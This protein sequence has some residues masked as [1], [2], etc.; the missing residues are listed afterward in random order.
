MK[1]HSKLRLVVVPLFLIGLG[2]IASMQYLIF[3]RFLTKI[4]H[5][6]TYTIQ[7]SL[8]WIMLVVSIALFGFFI[9]LIRLVYKK[10]VFI[11]IKPNEQTISF[12]YPF[13]FLKKECS[14]DDISGFYFSSFYSRIGDFK[15]IKI[16][17]KDA[18]TVEF[19]D[20]ETANLRALEAFILENFALINNKTFKKLTSEERAKELV[21]NKNF[22]IKQAKGNK[23]SCYMYIVLVVFIILFD[24]YYAHSDRHLGLGLYLFCI[25]FLAFVI[26]KIIQSNKTIRERE[27][28]KM[29]LNLYQI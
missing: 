1:I 2:T 21:A 22:D 14:F 25:A 27:A 23:F 3:I 7:G 17:T 28:E 15:V 13:Q 9:Y 29:L 10:L 18:L 19:S 5:Y 20:Y 11:T 4:N 8:F 12:H 16:R 24:N 6:S 26:T